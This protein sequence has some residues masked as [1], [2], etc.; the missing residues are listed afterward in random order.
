MEEKKRKEAE[1]KLEELQEKIIHEEVE[2]EFI[3]EQLQAK[4]IQL[5][6]SRQLIPLT[7]VVY[8][9]FSFVL[10]ILNFK[11]QFRTEIP[12]PILPII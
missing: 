1:A 10:K 3:R 4:E 8:Y 6:K 11:I 2:L 5:C 12:K 9:P 7:S